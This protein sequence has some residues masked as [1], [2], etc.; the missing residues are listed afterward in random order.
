MHLNTT[1][2]LRTYMASIKGEEV[3]DGDLIWFVC[4]LNA[5]MHF[6]CGSIK[7]L[8]S[9][10]LMG[11]APATFDDVQYWLDTQFEESD[12]EDEESM[13]YGDDNVKTHVNNFYGK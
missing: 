6:D 12:E 1:E 8:A 4:T 2:A 10:F 9:V 7:D 13:E 5:G 11:V 3:S